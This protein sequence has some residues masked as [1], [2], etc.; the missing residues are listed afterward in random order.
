MLLSPDAQQGLII[1]CA[2]VSFGPAT[3]AKEITFSPIAKFCKRLPPVAL[4]SARYFAVMSKNI[5]NMR[6]AC[7]CR[8]VEVYREE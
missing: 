1:V 3:P 2:S 7:I 5:S 8:S 4:H 6:R